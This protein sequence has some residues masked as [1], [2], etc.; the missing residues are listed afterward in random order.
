MMKHTKCVLGTILAIG[1]GIF[2]VATA[3]VGVPL[4]IQSEA[5]PVISS[6]CLQL[7]GVQL[8][9]TE[10]W[11]IHSEQHIGPEF[12]T[13]MESIAKQ[14][15]QALLRTFDASARSTPQKAEE[16]VNTLISQ[17]KKVTL[18][19]VTHRIDLKNERVYLALVSNAKKTTWI[20]F[21]F[22]QEPNGHWGYVPQNAENRLLPLIIESLR[23]TESAGVH[24]ICETPNAKLAATLEEPD[25]GVALHFKSSQ[26]TA[27]AFANQPS[28][29]AVLKLRDAARKRDINEYMTLLT[30]DGMAS[31]GSWA[32]TASPK[33]INEYLSTWDSVEPIGYLDLAPVGVIVLSDAN[34]KARSIYTVERNGRTEIM[35]LN[36]IANADIL[37]KSN[38]SPLLRNG[39]DKKF[40][41]SLQSAKR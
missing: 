24:Q 13:M 40:V 34:K 31:L 17:W 2:Q 19:S 12:A 11:A 4:V 15:R 26:S 22:R 8:P 21:V 23:A 30:R 29:R 35:N 18:H 27:V 10:W 38:N 20:P 36:Q 3:S 39:V 41:M 32:N 14:D 28:V 33:E 25:L 16:L 5:G 9:S 6:A 1:L 37:L 7:P